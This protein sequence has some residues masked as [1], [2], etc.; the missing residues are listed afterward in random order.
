[1]WFQAQNPSGDRAFPEL[2]AVFLSPSQENFR[3]LSEVMLRPIPSTSSPIHYLLVMQRFDIMYG[4]SQRK[5]CSVNQN[6]INVFFY[7]PRRILRNTTISFIST[8]HHSVAFCCS[9]Y[10]PALLHHVYPF[11]WFQN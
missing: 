9:D 5:R 2:S 11:D 10:V 3:I 8:I 4:M 1:M 6:K 7:C